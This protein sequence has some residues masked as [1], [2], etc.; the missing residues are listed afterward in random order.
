[1][2]LDSPKFDDFVSF[3]PVAFDNLVFDLKIDGGFP[4]HFYHLKCSLRRI[5]GLQYDPRLLGTSFGHDYKIGSV[6][7]KPDPISHFLHH[8][9]LLLDY[10]T[11]ITLFICFVNTQKSGFYACLFDIIAF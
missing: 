5:F 8:P 10:T 11:S 7:R 3:L 9:H 4:K 2:R 1:M 6:H